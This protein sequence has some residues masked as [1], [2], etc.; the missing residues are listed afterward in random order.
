MDT[1]HIYLVH[2]G[3]PQGGV[4]I[5]KRKYYGFKLSKFLDAKNVSLESEIRILKIVMQT[6]LKLSEL[7]E[8]NVKRCYAYKTV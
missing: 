8:G 1:I 6:N 7:C 3:M 2:V 4:A 5:R